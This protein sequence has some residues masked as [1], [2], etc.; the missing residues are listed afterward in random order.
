MPRTDH[1][2]NL[3]AIALGMREAASAPQRTDAERRAFATMVGKIE[4]AAVHIR[5]GEDKR[6]TINLRK[7]A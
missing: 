1:A 7:R 3:F 2:A 4:A 6:Q 5:K